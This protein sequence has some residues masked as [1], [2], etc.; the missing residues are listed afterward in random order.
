MITTKP[1]FM[2]TVF[3][4]LLL[5]GCDSSTPVSATNPESATP[6]PVQSTSGF[7]STFAGNGNYGYS[8]DGTSGS[9]VQMKY[10]SGVA[11]NSGNLFIADSNNYR[12]RMIPSISGTHF[13]ISMVANG[14]YT[15]AGDGNSAYAGDNGPATSASIQGTQ[16]NGICADPDG[17]VYITDNTASVVRMISASSGTFFGINMIEG[18]IYTIAGNISVSGS[19]TG[20]G[21]VA[22]SAGLKT[23]NGIA[24]DSL[25]NVYVADTGNDAIRMIPKVTGTYFGAARTAG[26]IYSLAGNGSNGS[27]GDTGLASAALLNNPYGVAIDSSGD[28]IIADYSNYK[29]RMIAATTGS[30]FGITM[31]AGNIYKIAGNGMSSAGGDGGI[32]TTVPVIPTALTT[33]TLGNIYALEMLPSVVRMICR[34]PGKYY[35]IIMESGHIYTVAGN[36]SRGYMGDGAIGTSAELSDPSGISIDNAGNLLIA[37]FDNNVI[38]KIQP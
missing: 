38:R 24:T 35:G 14:I 11:T 29:I 7:I 2:S 25:G 9:N 3:G 22:T 5:Y 16:V 8:P 1:K 15:I 26:F 31:T 20:D 17:N 28:V 12:I 13:G 19:Y 33:D 27:T 32:A 37:D 36:R 30:F 10:P 6:T 23:P 34:V 18:Y 21:A 4:I